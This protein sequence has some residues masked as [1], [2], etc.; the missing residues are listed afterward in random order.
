MYL[1]FNNY[2]PLSSFKSF[3]ITGSG[4]DSK[5]EWMELLLG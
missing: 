4:E 1:N 5:N 3:D 2:V